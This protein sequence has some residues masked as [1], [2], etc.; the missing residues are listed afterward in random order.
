MVRFMKNADL[1]T[2]YQKEYSSIK[3][4]PSSYAHHTKRISFNE[5]CNILFFEGE[6]DE[7]FLIAPSIFNSYKILTIGNPYDIITAL[8]KAGNV[9]VIE[10]LEI[11]DKDF[12]LS[13]YASTVAKVLSLYNNIH[14][15]GHCLG[16]NF[17]IAASVIHP[18]RIKSLILLTTPW[19]YAHFAAPKVMYD[20]MG[21]GKAVKNLDHI[22][23]IYMQ[24]LFFLLSPESF[25][26]KLEFYQANQKDVGKSNFFEIERWQFSGH[27]IP[28]LA[29][30]ELMDK[31]IGNNI[32]QKGSW[33]VDGTIIDVNKL[34]MPIM[35]IL[36]K[37]DKL[38]P[39]NSASILHSF[40][41]IF[42]YNSGHIGYLVGSQREEF[43]KDLVGWV[44]TCY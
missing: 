6:G 22:P 9:Y 8:R 41:K 39:R 16:G 40:S 2:Q 35:L 19:D 30:D 36:G 44:L 15:I 18:E 17:A 29:Y 10:W 12:D 24:I 20:T 1:F 38:V 23:A 32:L 13:C 43:V 7:L 5:A 27:P 11:Q 31:F 3:D 28:R 37:K 4:E 14:L 25:E 26:Q 21:L 34:Q 33:V 42:E